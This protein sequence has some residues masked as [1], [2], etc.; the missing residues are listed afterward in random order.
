[1]NTVSP[2]AI[3]VGRAYHLPQ[4]EM[5]DRMR[6]IATAAPMKRLGKPEEIT[7]VVA[8]LASCD[9]SYVTGQEITVD[10]GIS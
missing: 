9:A 1:V 2:G 6:Q 10:G 4:D 3:D 5:A 7:G 8:F